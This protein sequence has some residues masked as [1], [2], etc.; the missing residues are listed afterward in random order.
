MTPCASGSAQT[1]VRAARLDENHQIRKFG[2][3]VQARTHASRIYNSAL[4]GDGRRRS[5]NVAGGS[6]NCNPRSKSRGL[7]RVC[8]GSAARRFARAVKAYAPADSLGI[9]GIRIECGNAFFIQ[10]GKTALR[11]PACR[12]PAGCLDAAQ[13]KCISHG[14]EACSASSDFTNSLGRQRRAVTPWPF[15]TTTIGRLMRMGCSA[16]ASSSSSSPTSFSSRRSS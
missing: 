8:K 12:I 6:A 2:C 4:Q 7:R 15:C 10:I 14:I 5:P 13:S 9:G 1:I 16:I 11:N 3:L